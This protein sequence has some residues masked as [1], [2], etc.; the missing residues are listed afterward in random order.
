MAYKWRPSKTEKKEFA[1]KMQ[2]SEFASAYNQRKEDKK[3]NKRASSKF[4]YETAGGNYVA[5]QKQH[6]FCLKNM[7]LFE[8][9]DEQNAANQVVFSFTCKEKTKHDYIHIVNEKIRKNPNL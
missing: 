3:A 2:N 7:N 8:T 4:D 5:T 1:E 6:D 9:N